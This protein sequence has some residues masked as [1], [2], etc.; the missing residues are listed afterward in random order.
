MHLVCA[1]AAAVIWF[2]LVS[3]AHDRPATPKIR[4][5]C[6]EDKYAITD[7]EL[8]PYFALPNVLDGLFGLAK[9][10]FDVDIEAADG[11]VCSAL[12]AMPSHNASVV[13]HS[14]QQ[15]SSAEQ[16]MCTYSLYAFVSKSAHVTWSVQSTFSFMQIQLAK[17]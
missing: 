10:L 17:H 14:H 6:R 4:A 2:E 3:C 16:G 11:E 8:R 7:E 12:S 9:R 5:R 1:V 15:G 13:G